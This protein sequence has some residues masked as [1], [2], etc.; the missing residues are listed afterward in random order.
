MLFP[1]AIFS[2]AFDD[3]QQTIKLTWELGALVGS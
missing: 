1:T 3:K 2:M